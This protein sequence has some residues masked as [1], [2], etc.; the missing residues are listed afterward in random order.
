MVVNHFLTL[1]ESS[2]Y[3]LR[4]SIVT[5]MKHSVRTQKRYY[6]ERP[7]ALKKKKAIDFLSSAAARGIEAGDVEIVSNE[8]DEEG[9]IHCLPNPGEFVGL[10]AANSTQ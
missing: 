5:L 1:P 3:S 8:E 10:V 6:D 9:H 4:E 2:D 7:L